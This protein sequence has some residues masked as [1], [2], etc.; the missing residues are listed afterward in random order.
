VN[1]QVFEILDIWLQISYITFMEEAVATAA[2]N[3]GL[4]F[5]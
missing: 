1:E 2:H 4:N 5:I 3:E